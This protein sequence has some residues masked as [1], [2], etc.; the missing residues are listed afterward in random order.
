[1]SSN[2]FQRLYLT[3]D[4]YVEL[5]GEGMKKNGMKG[6][7]HPEDLMYTAQGVIDV[8]DVTFTHLL[9]EARDEK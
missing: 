8:I 2:K 4:E 9:N 5:I 7:C 3:V 6:K 1:M